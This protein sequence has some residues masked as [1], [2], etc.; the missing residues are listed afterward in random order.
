MGKKRKYVLNI[1][2]RFGKLTILEEQVNPSDTAHHYYL[3]KCDCGNTKLIRD[4][5]IYDGSTQSCGCLW[6]ESMDRVYEDRRKKTE[7][8]I[9]YKQGSLTVIE[10]KGRLDG[11]DIFYL[12]KCD[13]GREILIRHYCLK[14][15]QNSCEC[16][17]LDKARNAHIESSRERRIYPEYLLS[18]L[19][20]KE[21]K[22]RLEKRELVYEYK[23]LFKCS[24]CGDLFRRSLSSV[25]RSNK[26]RKIP[27]V[28]CKNCSNQTSSQE[29]EIYNY[30][31]S[32][33]LHDEDIRR[34]DRTILFPLELDFF[35]PKYNL[36]I[37]YNGSYYHSDTSKPTMYHRDKFL[38]CE[39]KGIHLISVY[40]IDWINN[41][42]K[43]KE[44]IKSIVCPYEK[45][46]ARKC[47]VHPIS[48]KEAEGFY[49]MYHIQGSCIL[50]KINYG[51]FYDDKLIS[52]MGFGSSS[53]HNRKNKDGD[54]ELHR[55]VSR[56][57][58]CVVGG[59]S[60]LLKRFEEDYHPNFLLSYSWNDWFTG[61]VYQKLGFKFD[62][63]V[64]PDYYWYKD[65]ESIPKRKCR[66]KNLE[67]LYPEL[68]KESLE[69]NA[70]NKEDYIMQSLGAVKVH[71]SGAK[72]WV[73]EYIEEL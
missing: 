67:K 35:I 42:D 56:S 55:F 8:P 2:D 37:E 4:R 15:G 49:V 50:S 9:G 64:Q 51:L 16:Q 59:A 36:A 69:K 23:A 61:G 29:D 68:Y 38:N 39:K 18:L 33:G 26:N 1:G 53:Y 22:E 27:S 72:R 71:R 7:L 62:G 40:E 41:N 20:D 63:N 31:I 65:G 6:K 13:C 19:Q 73:K 32:L 66:L 12:C 47:T 14:R 45:I 52:V 10:N 28:V 60:K 30:L 44:L 58:L 11:K 48:E 25:I 46:Y 70:S 21:E 24:V 57:G 17:K 54:Y 43:I 3:C 34:N 5:L